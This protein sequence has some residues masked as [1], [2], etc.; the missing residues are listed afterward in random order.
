M[1]R[2]LQFLAISIVTSTLLLGV[3][4][5]AESVPAGGVSAGAAAAKGDDQPSVLFGDGGIFAQVTNV[6]LFI[7]GAISVIMII[8]GGLRYV[9][10]GGDSAN[11]S[12]AK[13]T[14]LYAIVGIIVALLA[15]AAVSFIT[16]TFASGGSFTGGG[17]GGGATNF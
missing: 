6:M 11:V 2:T 10:S 16:G 15:Y 4:A 14:I 13:N 9:L 17:S 1:K 12:A 7:I 5:Y 3:S 8:I